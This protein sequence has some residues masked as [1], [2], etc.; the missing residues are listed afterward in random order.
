MNQ[1]SLLDSGFGKPILK[2]VKMAE[3]ADPLVGPPPTTALIE[4]IETFGILQP[5][6]LV[7]MEGVKSYSVA[8]GRRRIKAIRSIGKPTFHAYVFRAGEISPGAATLIENEH[9]SDNLVAQIDAVSLLLQNSS[10]EQVCS[11]VGIT[12]QR[13]REIQKLQQSLVPELMSALR[14]N[15]MA[16]TIALKAA[17]LTHEQQYRIA[18]EERITG[19]MVREAKTAQVEQQLAALPDELFPKET[20]QERATGLFAELLALLPEDKRWKQK[21]MSLRKEIENRQV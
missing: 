18:G 16:R 12:K 1:I 8:W 4:S 6:G 9:R 5:P 21:V 15:R 13:L 17:K 20:I 3:I 19:P 7:Q 2:R 11:S 10:E 14:Q